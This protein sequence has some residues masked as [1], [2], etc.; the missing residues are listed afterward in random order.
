MLVAWHPQSIYLA[1]SGSS[2]IVQVYH[3]TGSLAGTFSIP[4]FIS[5]Q[6]FLLLLFTLLLL[7]SQCTYLC[8]DKDGEILSAL[9]KN[10]TTIYCWKPSNQEQSKI[11]IGSPISFIAWAKSG[12]YLAIGCENGNV[13]L[14]DKTINKKNSIRGVFT[15][16]ILCGAWNHRNQIVLGSEDGSTRVLTADGKILRSCNFKGIP[17]FLD[18]GDIATLSPTKDATV[19]ERTFLYVDTQGMIRLVTEP[20]DDME[21]IL[22]K[23]FGTL[24]SCGCDLYFSLPQ[25][26]L[27]F[28]SSIDGMV[29]DIYISHMSLANF[30]SYHPTS[31]KFPRL[32]IVRLFSSNASADLRAR[33]LHQL[34]GHAP[35]LRLPC[36]ATQR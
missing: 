25:L 31:L 18:W 11:D 7:F 14:L 17:T 34:P 27:F 8:W 12:P 36:V 32:S 3:R 9:P 33:R 23:T 35:L 5:P 15:K 20:D 6:Y 1:A 24:K 4:R 21:I 10:S 22:N 13:I 26:S 28:F 16:R 29:T 2:C 19:T 30:L